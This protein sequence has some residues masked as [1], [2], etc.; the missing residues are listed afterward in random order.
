MEMSLDSDTH[1]DTVTV[2]RDG[3]MTFRFQG[4]TEI[5]A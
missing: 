5:E 3:R 1:V 4:G 2:H